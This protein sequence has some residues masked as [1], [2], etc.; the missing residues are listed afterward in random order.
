MCRSSNDKGGNS[1]TQWG[2]DVEESLARSV[3]VPGVGKR[4]DN[5]KDI[6]RACQHEGDDR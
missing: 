6:W 3:R 4:G 1:Q 2:R 5:T